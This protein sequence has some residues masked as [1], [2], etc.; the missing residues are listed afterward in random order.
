MKANTHL[1]SKPFSPS[2]T[3]KS[4]AFHSWFLMSLIHPHG[5]SDL[6]AEKNAIQLPI[7]QS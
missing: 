4:P 5:G 7:S 6:V 3:A 1:N 2:L